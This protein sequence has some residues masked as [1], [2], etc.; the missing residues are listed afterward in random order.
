M[1]NQKEGRFGLR[2]VYTQIGIVSFGE[3]PC[4]TPGWGVYVNVAYFME[5][6]LNHLDA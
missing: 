3:S 1:I 6:I 5:W 4:G 2:D